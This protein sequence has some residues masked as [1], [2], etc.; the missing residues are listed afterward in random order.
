MAALQKREKIMASV[1]GAFLIAFLLY[2]FV[3]TKSDETAPQAAKKNAAP[4]SQPVVVFDPTKGSG[5]GKTGVVTASFAPMNIES[6]GQDPFHE[7]Y[8]LAVFDTSQTDSSARPVLKGII[9]KGNTA[10]VLINDSILR[11]GEQ[12]GELKILDIKRERVICKQGNN[13]ITLFLDD[14]K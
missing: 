10:F 13:T 8:R 14:E 3:F 5:T 4:K 11:K 12:M 2:Q 6:W 1:A 7:A 9:W